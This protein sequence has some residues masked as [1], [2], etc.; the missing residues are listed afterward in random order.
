MSFLDFLG[1]LKP[2]VSP[3]NIAKRALF[4]ED[5]ITETGGF[6][7]GTAIDIQQKMAEEYRKISR[8]SAYNDNVA[9]K[10]TL[11]LVYPQDLFS[12]ESGFLDPCILFHMK[13]PVFRDEKILKRIALYMPP[14][15]KVNYGANWSK[16]DLFVT[17]NTAQSI[18]NE[19][20]KFLDNLQTKSTIEAISTAAK[21]I[22]KGD[23]LSTLAGTIG[24]GYA[25]KTLTGNSLGQAA[26]AIAGKSINPMAGL[27]FS[28]VNPRTFTFDFELLARTWDESDDI[29]DIIGTFKYGMHP[30]AIKGFAPGE[31]LSGYGDPI[32][33]DYPKTFDIFLFAGF[34]SSYLFNFERCALTSVDVNYNN[35]ENASFFWNGAPV[36]IGLSL[37]FKE[38]ELLTRD[39]VSKGY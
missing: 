33:L 21:D 13:E 25:K 34:H 5:G 1:K 9:L 20:T 29:R 6:L 22:V 3:A 31:A 38:T 11:P 18:R 7:Q 8:E 36:N 28:S 12:E 19:A 39:R 15:I 16:V 30:E 14:N 2:Y 35:G 4:K 37:T 32:F 17:K 10:P 23:A 24:R 27:S 26:S